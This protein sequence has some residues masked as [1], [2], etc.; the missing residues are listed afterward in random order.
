VR[1]RDPV[2]VV[3]TLRHTTALMVSLVLSACARWSSSPL[4]L[5]VLVTGVGRSAAISHRRAAISVGEPPPTD[6]ALPSYLNRLGEGQR[7]LW[8]PRFRRSVCRRRALTTAARS[9]VPLPPT[10]RPSCQTPRAGRSPS[11]PHARRGPCLF[12]GRPSFK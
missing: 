10:L 6:P 11:R 5:A 8:C 2:H 9:P 4:Y 1:R 7:S 12:P 3:R